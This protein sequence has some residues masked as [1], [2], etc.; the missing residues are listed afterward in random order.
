VQVNGKKVRK[1]HCV[2]VGQLVQVQLP[3]TERARPEPGIRIDLV[4]TRDDLVV[5]D[6]P[7]GLPSAGLRGNSDNTL[8]G[9]LVARFPEMASVGFGALEPGLLHRLDTFTSGLLIA[10]RSEQ[11]FLALRKA[12][13]QGRLSKRYQAI[14][15]GGHI[16]DAGLIDA[17]IEPHPNNRRKVLVTS[18][19]SRRGRPSQTN[20]RILERHSDL[21]LLELSLGAAYRHQVRAHLAFMGWPIVGDTLYGGHPA[22]GLAPARHALHACY[23]RCAGASIRDF[24]VTSGLPG[25]M[26]RCLGAET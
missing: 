24:E 9:A 2:S 10:A 18:I 19:T 13:S 5:V 14:V 3:S 22:A 1:G 7:A 11:A 8:A 20:F 25:D 4:L 12:L 17:N 6:K 21:T 15:T 26:L 16:P 23:I